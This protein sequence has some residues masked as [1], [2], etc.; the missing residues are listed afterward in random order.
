MIHHTKEFKM[1]LSYFLSLLL[2]ACL[3]SIQYA[4]AAI[5]TLTADTSISNIPLANRDTTQTL[6]VHWIQTSATSD[7]TLQ[8]ETAVSTVYR[9][10]NIFAVQKRQIFFE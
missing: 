7:W 6:V 9:L 1:N 3:S 10:V 4:S 2:L 8:S 5:S